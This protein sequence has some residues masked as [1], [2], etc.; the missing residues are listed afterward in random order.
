[1]ALPTPAKTWVIDPCN[2]V[3]Y[4]T[5]KIEQ[6]AT[7][8]LA[9]KNSLLTMSGV[10]VKGSCNG[11][12][13]AMDGV[14]RW[15]SAT[16][17]STQASSA[18][19]AQSW[20]VLD[21]ANMGGAEL[22]LTNH[23][24]VAGNFGVQFSPGGLYAAAG[25]ATH[26][27]TATD[28]QNMAATPSNGGGLQTSAGLVT[29]LWSTW[30]ASDGSA[31]A[32]AV[33]AGGAWQGMMVLQLVT[34]R[35]SVGTFS[36]AAVGLRLTPAAGGVFSSWGTAQAYCRLNPGGGAVNV[37]GFLGAEGVKN[38]IVGS[39]LTSIAELQGS[40]HNMFQVSLWSE[41][42]TARGAVGVLVDLWAGNTG[43]ADGDTYPNDT[44]RLFVQ[45]GDLILPWDGSSVVMT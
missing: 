3:A 38:G 37:I 14:D 45:F 34:S 43:A 12:T 36:P 44:S 39:Q 26:K 5:T 23:S 16:D 19:A 42:A 24:T 27:P 9:I 11:T 17:V 8:M 20:I 6:V 30:L 22:L 2:S 10:T 25:T 33:A 40:A 32:F 1:M 4:S 28:D 35:V 18:T 31:L 15:A 7:I 29:Q 41:T 13:G 21:L